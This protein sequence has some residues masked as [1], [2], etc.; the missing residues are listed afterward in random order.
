V[1]QRLD[2][3][4]FAEPSRDDRAL[5]GRGDRVDHHVVAVVDPSADH[6]LAGDL[7]EERLVARH[8]AA[9]HRDV[10]LAVLREERRLAGVNPAVEGDGQ[11]AA[12]PLVAHQAHAARAR[13]VAF[14]CSPL[15]A[16]D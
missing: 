3:G 14:E 4:L 6:A 7:E 11:G 9:V 8:E 5:G 10:P 12:E 13:R 16:S 1:R 2:G 15:A